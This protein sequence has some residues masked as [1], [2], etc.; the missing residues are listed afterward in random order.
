MI[1]TASDVSSVSLHRWEISEYIFEGFVIL[2]CA[3]EMVADLGES[4]LGETRK[5]H[6]ER[7]STMLLVAALSVS[8]ICLVRT[9]ELSGNAIGSLG[10]EAGDADTKAKDAIADSAT[11]LSQAKNALAKSDAAG[12]SASKAVYKSEKATIGSSKALTEVIAAN[13]RVA[14]LNTQ[15]SAAKAQLEAVDAKRAELEKSLTNLAICTAPRV[16]PWWVVGGK[17]GKS[18][19]DPLRQFAGYQAIIEFL[20]DDAE[21]RRRCIQSC[22]IA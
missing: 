12:T 4:W 10:S 1:F 8:L 14:D 22:V 20:P 16:I 6:L 13:R 19:V 11:A 17:S 15:L 3:G 21:T 9:N 2:A 5:R 18:S 7:V